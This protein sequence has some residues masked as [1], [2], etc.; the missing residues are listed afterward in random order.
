MFDEASLGTAHL[1]QGGTE[2]RTTA[3]PYIIS[4]YA[5]LQKTTPDRARQN[6]KA[7]KSSVHGIFCSAMKDSNPE[8]H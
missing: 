8:P 4:R 3:A 1:M 2:F 5:P 6:K 7:M